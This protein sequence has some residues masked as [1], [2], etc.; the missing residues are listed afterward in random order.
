VINT[1][2]NYLQVLRQLD[3]VHSRTDAM[4]RDMPIWP[5][6]R[7]LLGYR[8]HLTTVD[9]KMD[10]SW[11]TINWFSSNSLP[12]LLYNLLDKLLSYGADHIADAPL[13]VAIH[14]N[15]DRVVD[16]SSSRK[17]NVVLGGI[18]DELA[19]LDL[20]FT[21]WD[22]HQPIW[23]T[24]TR[25]GAVLKHH[26]RAVKRSIL[27][28]PTFQK[29]LDQVANELRTF[30]Y[31]FSQL[32]FHEWASEQFALFYAQHLIYKD[33]LSHTSIKALLVYNFYNPQTMGLIAAAK[34]KGIKVLE[35]QHSQIAKSHFAFSSFIR[36]YDINCWR[37][38]VPDHFLLWRE[39]DRKLISEYFYGKLN[40]QASVVGRL[41]KRNTFLKC[42]NSKLE[43]EVVILVALQGLKLPAYIIDTIGKSDYV[44]WL[45]RE[46]PRYPISDSYREEWNSLMN[47]CNHI[48]FD[49]T[50]SVE[51]TLLN[52]D[53]VLTAFSG[54][55]LEA[56][57]LSLPV[58]ICDESG[59][60]VYKEEI[61][62]DLM[63]FIKDGSHFESEI[64]KLNGKKVKLSAESIEEQ[65]SLNY[66]ASINILKQY[67]L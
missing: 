9:Q 1:R 50:T 53:A 57:L 62:S 18:V 45:I 29:L 14:S 51:C 34:K 3:I 31:H 43:G 36:N 61:A 67:V 22:L 52:V 47:N 58:L 28:D 63:V 33:L 60:D 59:A 20:P 21:I 7:M 16:D 5:V 19:S 8:L 54:I 38:F 37:W 2:E 30:Q 6:V 32:S 55:A 39:L 41:F 40:V 13:V 26:A 64:I 11:P 35:Y 66:K 48:T 56:S 27:K 46:H 23:K 65:L 44:K 17:S 10:L 4:Y 42:L 49:K 15:H 25:I 24:N 12:D